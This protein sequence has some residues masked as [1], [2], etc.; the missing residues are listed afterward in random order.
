MARNGWST[1]FDEPIVLD[2]GTTLRTLQQ[3]IQYL[4][5]TVPKLVGRTAQGK[6]ACVCTMS[7]NRLPPCPLTSENRNSLAMSQGRPR[8][9]VWVGGLEFAAR[10]RLPNDLP[11]LT[12]GVD[13]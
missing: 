3:A 2:D 10:S 8:M 5:K 13:L 1:R 6:N 4:A 11:A 7:T 12:R 9:R